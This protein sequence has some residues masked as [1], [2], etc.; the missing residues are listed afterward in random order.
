M[1]VK[2]V[3]KSLNNMQ[4]CCVNIKFCQTAWLYMFYTVSMNIPV[5]KFNRNSWFKQLHRGRMCRHSCFFRWGNTYWRLWSWKSPLG[6]WTAHCGTGSSRKFISSL[7]ELFLSSPT[8]THSLHQELGSCC[9][10]E[11]EICAN[12]MVSINVHM[13]V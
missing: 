4:E 6:Q 8:V 5:K 3:C 12:Y 10:F 7:Q 9:H 11:G 2:Q 1:K 13:H